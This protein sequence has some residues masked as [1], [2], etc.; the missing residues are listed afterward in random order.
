VVVADIHLN[1][2]YAF[3]AR[4]YDTYAIET[5]GIEEPS[6]VLVTMP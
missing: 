6:G 2:V 1:V 5:N 4:T 3:R